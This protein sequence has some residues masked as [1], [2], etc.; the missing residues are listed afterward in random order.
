M[1]FEV[2]ED[3]INERH[4]NGFVHREIKR[5]SNISGLAFDNIL[6]TEVSELKT[7]FKTDLC[8]PCQAGASRP[9]SFFRSAGSVEKKEWQRPTV[10]KNIF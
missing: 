5:P 8:V 4:K 10:K 1:W 6:L 3:E 9:P 7:Y 2:F